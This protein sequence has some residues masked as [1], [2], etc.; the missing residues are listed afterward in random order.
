MNMTARLYTYLL[1][2]T[3]EAPALKALRAEIASG[4]ADLHTLPATFSL[5]EVAELEAGVSKTT[6]TNLESSSLQDPELP[7]LA[8]LE[9]PHFDFNIK[10][11]D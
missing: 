9:L 10:P 2:H 1:G 4:A 3:R 8:P 7:P 11:L 5:A 6:L